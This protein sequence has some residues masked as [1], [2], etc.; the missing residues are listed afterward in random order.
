MG[1]F[2]GGP[3][4]MRREEFEA[5]KAF[6]SREEFEAQKAFKR[7]REMERHFE[8]LITTLPFSILICDHCIMGL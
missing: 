1:A 5:R 7:K 3:P 4:I 6:K 2:N 8:R